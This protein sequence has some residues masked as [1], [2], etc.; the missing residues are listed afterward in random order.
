MNIRYLVEL[1]HDERQDLLDR[2]NKGELGARKL[3]RANILLMADGHTY[4]D[5]DIAHALS[6]S[7]STVARTRKRCVEESAEAALSER[8]RPGASR[9]L[10]TL[11]EAK[12][13]A[14]ACTTA[15][16]GRARWTL[17][18]LADE[19][20]ALCEDL[21]DVSHETVRQRLKENQLKP[22]LKKMWCIRAVDP[23]FLWRMEDVLA[24][25]AAP[26]DP[27]F[28]VICFDEGLKQ[29]IGE[30]RE[31]R[32]MQPGSPAQQD[33]HYKR[34]GTAKLMVLQDVHRP[35]R[36][37]I[38]TQ[39]RRRREFALTMK[40][41]VDEF[42]PDAERIRVVLDQ[43]NTHGPE[44]L[45]ETFPAAEARRITEKLEFH[46]TPK[47]A[48]WLN[49]VEIEIGVL[50]SQCLD[51]RIG[52]MKTMESEVAAWVKRRN[53]EKAQINWLFTIDKAREKL[54]RHYPEPTLNQSPSP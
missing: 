9:K 24:L 53:D 31:P 3:K 4:T 34:N 16:E 35:W 37:V 51:R 26:A 27:R 8:Q 36:E 10:K 1:T 21:E 22:W 20:V 19:L 29:L 30:V 42:Y 49:M 23:A 11:Q 32:P 43:L 40:R 33:T 15:P 28:P 5:L 39:R 17:H 2:V 25:Y 48:S 45:Y 52:D 47:H 18:L 7:E 6:T 54:A 38:V 50:M 14:L 44:S 41:L 13:V 12:L 46:H